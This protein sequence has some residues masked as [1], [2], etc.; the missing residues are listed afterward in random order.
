M[1][2][3]HH[4]GHGEYRIVLLPENQGGFGEG[5]LAD[6]LE[7]AFRQIRFRRRSKK[8]GQQ[9][10]RAGCDAETNDKQES[11]AVDKATVCG[12]DAAA[13]AFSRAGRGGGAGARSRRS[14]I[15]SG[16]SRRRRHW[17]ALG[18][19]QPGNLFCQGE[20]TVILLSKQSPLFGLCLNPIQYRYERHMPDA[21]RMPIA[22]SLSLMAYGASSSLSPA[23]MNRQV[24]QYSTY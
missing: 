18:K 10:E 15:R 7:L 4:G 20:Y 19:E 23:S 22:C 12:A 9:P 24:N 16:G 21:R 6:G 13:G 5:A 2:L 1:Q 8:V 3:A 14:M 11:P 17:L